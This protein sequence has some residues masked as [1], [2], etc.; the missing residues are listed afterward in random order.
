MKILESKFVSGFVSGVAGVFIIYS[1]LVMTPEQLWRWLFHPDASEKKVERALSQPTE[2]ILSLEKQLSILQSQQLEQYKETR[3]REERLQQ[4]ISK[5][6][7]EVGK[8]HQAKENALE[9]LA[10]EK[11]EVTRLNNQI[12]VLRNAS[13]LVATA[14]V[15]M[16][17]A[18][19]H[20]FISYHDEMERVA[21]QLRNFL[22]NLGVSVQLG[23]K[24]KDS[25]AHFV[26]L[27]PLRGKNTLYYKAVE[28]LDTALNLLDLLAEHDFETLEKRSSL[29]FYSNW[30]EDVLFVIS[31]WK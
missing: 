2:V 21:F 18:G 12:V 29:Q 26:L 14:A 5:L 17:L 23:P 9:E 8:A 25:G 6:E 13:G 3:I 15:N 31:L 22:E 20:V 1:A 4:D 24:S 28:S 16:K 30:P 19:V 10:R 11:S 27:G 7:V